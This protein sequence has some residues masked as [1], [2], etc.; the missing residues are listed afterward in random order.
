MDLIS[1]TILIGSLCIFALLIFFGVPVPFGFLASIIFFSTLKGID[2]SFLFPIGFS[3]I[4]S[5]VLLSM[6]FFILTGYLVSKGSIATRLIDLADAIVGRLPGGLGLVVIVVSAVFGAISGAAASSVVAI[7]TIM[8]PEMEK[9][10]YP[11]GYSAALVSSSSVLSVLIPPSMAMI[12]YAFLT[13]QSVAAC[14]LSTVGPGILLSIFFGI[15]NA[16]MVKNIPTVQVSPKRPFNEHIRILKAKSKRALSALGLPILILGGIYGG[17]MT[18]TEAA[19]ASAVYC[20]VLS[21]LIY[22]EIKMREACVL[23]RSSAVNSG[24]MMIMTFFAAILGRLYTMEQVPQLI[25]QALFGITQ[26]KLLLLLLV[27]IILILVGMVVDM[28]SGVLLITPILFPVILSMG[29]H[30]LHFAA[31]VGTNLS[32]GMLTPPMAGILYIGAKTGEVSV[33]KMLKPVFAFILFCFV[34]V[35]IITSYWPTLSLFLP[36]LMGFVK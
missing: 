27:N 4:N 15:A 13:G 19:A 23:L 35:I 12:M 17:I 11:R 16:I 8:I 5:V 25:A 34:P 1:I 21:V 24:A 28:I 9:R 2:Y 18:P 6:P 31:I 26:N 22:R 20:F 32:M 30:P 29:I 33:D 36:R 14:F 10:G 3:N 7:G